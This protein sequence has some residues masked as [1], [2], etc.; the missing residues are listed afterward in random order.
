MSKVIK[1]SATTIGDSIS[2]LALYHTAITAS[3]LLSASVSASV[4]TGSGATVTVEDNVTT[5]YAVCNDGGFCDGE[6]V[7]LTVSLFNPTTR[8]FNFYTS[9]S[10][11]GGSIEM[12]YPF[13]ISA[14]TSSFTASVDFTTYP[15][16]V[17]EAN[18][19]AGFDDIF[20][21]WYYSNSRNTSFSTSSIITLTDTTFTGSSTIYG[22]FKDRVLDSGWQLVAGTFTS[23]S[24]SFTG[25][26]R[27]TLYTGS[28]VSGSVD[29]GS[30]LSGS[31]YGD[32]SSPTTTTASLT[33]SNFYLTGSQLF[34]KGYGLIG[35]GNAASYALTRFDSSSEGVLFGIVSS[36]GE[37]NLNTGSLAGSIYGNDGTSGSWSV[38]Y[39]SSVTYQDNNGSGSFYS[40]EA[41]G[42]VTMSGLSLNDA[43]TYQIYVE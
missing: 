22:W 39:S 35:I 31:G 42:I 19:G 32:S 16:A 10:D 21:G 7:S 28:I 4:L 23:S 27:G 12:T 14:T 17:V 40:P 25:F 34:N 13:T 26:H 29:T 8:W 2:T 43:T 3:N 24:V 20:Q 18:D 37:G 11:E 1:I 30:L 33:G 5:F 36:S 9:G 38:S 41:T 6:T 15:N